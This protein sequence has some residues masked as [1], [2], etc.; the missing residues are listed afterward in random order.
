MLMRLICLVLGFAFGSI[1]TGFVIARLH[2]VD[3]RKAGALHP[4]YF[5]IEREG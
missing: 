1:P 4:A 2:G 5:E 3:L